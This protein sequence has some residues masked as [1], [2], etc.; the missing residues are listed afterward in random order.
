MGYGRMWAGRYT[1]ETLRRTY[2]NGENR[3]AQEDIIYG[4][5]HLSREEFELIWDDLERANVSFEPFSKVDALIMTLFYISQG[6]GYY[7]IGD[8]FQVDGRLVGGVVN[9]CLDYLA[10]TNPPE[11][12]NTVEEVFKHVATFEAKTGMPNMMGIVDTKYL[13]GH[14]GTEPGKKL[15]LAVDSQNKIIFANVIDASVLDLNSIQESGLLERVLET[16]QFY[17][18]WPTVNACHIPLCPPFIGAESRLATSAET[19]G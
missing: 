4:R 5:T 15:V 14:S 18:N 6:C 13:A 1:S 3:D 17:F 8:I 12:P 11:L 19:G 9:K 10:T 2:S 7:T 16:K